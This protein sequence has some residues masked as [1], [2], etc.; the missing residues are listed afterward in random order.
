MAKK[1]K[2]IKVLHFDEST[3]KGERIQ[4]ASVLIEI[5]GERPKLIQGTQVLKGDIN[6]KHTISYTIFDGK[7]IGKATYSIE[8]IEKK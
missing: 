3:Q 8:T 7:S 2:S 5:E 1:I 6:G 4:Q